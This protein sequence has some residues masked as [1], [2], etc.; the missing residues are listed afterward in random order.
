MCGICGQWDF[1]QTNKIEQQL[2]ENMCQVIRHRGPDDEGIYLENNVALGMRRLSIIDLSTGHQPI[3]NEDKTVW[4][5]YNG[6]IYNYRE[7]KELLEKK[8]HRF[9]TSTDTEVLV[10]LY[11][12]FG[13]ECVQK[14]Q[15]MFAF[16]IWDKR[17]I[18]M[19]L[20]RDRLGI[21]PLFYSLQNNKITFGS[22]IKSILEDRQIKK[23]INLPALHNFLSLNYIPSPQTIFTD[24]HKLPPGH[25]L[26]SQNGNTKIKQ[27]W[28]VDFTNGVVH[29][30]EYYA[31]RLLEL[32]RESVKKRL[33]S[34]VPLGALLSGGLDSS[35]VVA[36]MSEF[37][38][39]PVKT[40]SIG[41]EEKS[42]NELE[43]ARIIAQQFN[44][45]HH[46]LIVKPQIADLLPKLIWHF[47][48]PYADSSSIP[49]YYV[50][51][52][53][54]NYVTVALSGD[55]GDEIF[56][57]YETYAAY[58]TAELYKRIPKMIRS[59]MPRVVSLLPTS[60]RKIS[61]DYKAKRFMRGSEMPPEEGHYYWKV[62]FDEPE[63]KHLY[64]PN[65]IEQLRDFN[66]YSVFNSYYEKSR[67]VD[68]LSR[69]QYVDTKVYLAHDILVKVDKMSMANSLETRVPLLDHQLVEFVASI[70]ASLRLKNFSKKYILKRTMQHILPDKIVHRK[71]R[72]FNIPASAWLKNDLRELMLET[73]S[74]NNIRELGL[75]K[76]NYVHK[77]ITE[78][79]QNKIDHSRPIWGLLCFMLWHNIFM[80]NQHA[81]GVSNGTT[82]KTGS[83]KK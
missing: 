53:A 49:V 42:F 14:L 22:E 79:L 47:D 12:E 25:L 35:T 58:R 52:L 69:L 72:G 48:E 57:G 64:S 1:T 51:Q 36:L 45:D 19:L 11:E 24:I 62:I 67:H 70:P 33:M 60:D 65:V 46:E 68:M 29:D 6:E 66:S 28:D 76:E 26:I 44:T 59:V 41:F 7:L 2:I 27:Y 63:K 77:I 37:T 39:E 16:A 40:F 15:G 56:A 61:F 31:E 54:R 71:K 81:T 74:P 34:D 21:K 55:G 75:F 30:E 10:H 38:S 13:E 50:S 4:V 9:Y 78:H 8:N 18:R 32:L 20:A 5:V 82:S 17:N 43:Y 73:L 80:N 3:H 83:S 23:E